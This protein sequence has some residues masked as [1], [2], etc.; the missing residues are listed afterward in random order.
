MSLA[1]AVGINVALTE[2]LTSTG[3]GTLVQTYATDTA[4]AQLTVATTDL[5]YTITGSVGTTAFDIDL[6]SINN[7]SG[8]GYTT[9]VVRN[10]AGD[11]INIK[12]ITIYNTHATQTIKIGSSAANNFFTWQGT[13]NYIVIPAGGAF[14]MTYSTAAAVSTNGK[15]NLLGSGATTSLKIFIFGN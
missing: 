10:N 3:T 7:Q 6:T 11:F 8:T 12:Q 15:F 5:I 2:T 1:G 13:S 9:T 4:I 14:T